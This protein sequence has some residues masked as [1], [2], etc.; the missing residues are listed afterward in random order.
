MAKL[1]QEARMTIKT[2]S[3]KGV[4]GRETARLLGV[5]EGAVRYHRRRQEAGAV[6]GRSLQRRQAERFGRASEEWV[7]EVRH[8]RGDFVRFVATSRNKTSHLRAGI[9]TYV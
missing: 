1:C 8:F 2:L 5:S 6:D 9:P 4:C 7:T 3:A